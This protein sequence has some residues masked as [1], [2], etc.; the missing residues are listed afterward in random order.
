MAKS[1]D[2]KTLLKFGAHTS[3]HKRVNQDR[4]VNR[5]ISS[6][7]NRS[8]ALGEWLPLTV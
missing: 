7:E 8:T 4:H 3:I 1:G 6:S 2:V 5:T